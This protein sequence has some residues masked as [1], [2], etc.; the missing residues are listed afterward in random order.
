[1]GRVYQ[2]LTL[3]RGS[4]RVLTWAGTRDSVM[5]YSSERLGVERTANGVYDG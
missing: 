3:I 5:E 4:A 2:E 1:M